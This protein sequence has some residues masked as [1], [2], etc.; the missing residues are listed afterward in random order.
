LTFYDHSLSYGTAVK[1][2]GQWSPSHGKGQAYELQVTNLQVLGDNN[3]EANPLQPKYQTPEYLR[4]IPHLRTRVPHN[5]LVLRLR[6]QMVASLTKF[7]HENDFVQAH[8]PIITSSDCEGAGE[9]FSVSADSDVGEATEANDVVS[10]G[11]TPTPA[12]KHFFKTQKYLTVSAQ[13]HLEALAQSVGNVW[14]LSPTFRAER[15]DTPRHLAEFYMLEVEMCFISDLSSLMDLIENMLRAVATDLHSSR[16]G[17]ELLAHEQQQIAQSQSSSP[18]ASPDHASSLASSSPILLA[19]WK[20]LAQNPWPRITYAEAIDILQNASSTGATTFTVPPS[21]EEG[22]QAEHER[23]LTHHFNP[24]STDGERNPTPVFVTDYPT[25][26]KPFYMLPSTT[27]DTTTP[28]KTV[29]NFDL[30]VPSHL[31]LAGGSLRE[32]RLDLLRAAMAAKGL[33]S[34]T[35]ASTSEVTDPSSSP[36]SS[37]SG[38]LDWYEDL[39]RFGSAPH[40]GFGMGFDRLLGYLSGTASVRDVVTW[41][42]WSG[43]CDG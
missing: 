10:L 27:T 18:S 24:P 8:T 19:R 38:T 43:R 1:I 16:V 2:T 37:P 25:D 9:V 33:G 5:G 12:E 28:P 21:Y 4:T 34:G 22:L 36:S 11:A 13:L 7:F 39:R 41:P 30:L 15:S 42:R 17:R 29:A 23:Y 14:T 26:Q 40:G 6:S 20:G 31:E 35:A 3:V 32:H